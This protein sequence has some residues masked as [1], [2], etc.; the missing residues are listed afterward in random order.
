MHRVLRSSVTLKQQV[1]H[2]VE[3][4]PDNSPL[5]VEIRETLRLNVAISEAMAD[6]RD[7]RTYEAGEVTAKVQ[8][9]WP[10]QASA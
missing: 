7:G 1:Q 4:L 6:V 5:L 9:K 10:R 2:L 3:E 8:E